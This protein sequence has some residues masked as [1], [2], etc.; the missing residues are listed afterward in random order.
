MHRG[1]LR[2]FRAVPLPIIRSLM[3]YTSAECT[4]ENSAFFGQFLFPSSGV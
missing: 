2:M 3:T 1:K 4:E